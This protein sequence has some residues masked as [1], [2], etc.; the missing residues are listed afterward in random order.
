MFYNLKTGEL[1]FDDVFLKETTITTE[2]GEEIASVDTHFLSACYDEQLKELGFARVEQAEVPSFDED[3]E[4]IEEIKELDVINNIYK[5]S[6][7]AIPKS[8]ERLKELKIEKINQ[9]RDEVI[10]SGVE[11]K[12]HIFQSGES[13]RSLLNQ[14]I[15]LYGFNNSLPADFAWIAKDNTKVPMSLDE[16]RGLALLMGLKVNN[17]MLKARELKNAVLQASSA[18]QLEDINWE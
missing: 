17:N 10:E 8:L 14:A 9:K 12:N 1:K 15:T 3:R 5:I 6:Y 2:E 16:L 4:E 11:Y 18:E 13:D 7:R